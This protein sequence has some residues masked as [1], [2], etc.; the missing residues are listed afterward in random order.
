VDRLTVF[1]QNY[2]EVSILGFDVY[3]APE[4]TVD[5]DFLANRLGYGAFDPVITDSRAI[6]SLPYMAKVLGHL[7]Y[8][9]AV[10]TTPPLPA[11]RP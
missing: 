9:V 4:A 5:L 2:A 6:R 10:F 11:S 8:C 3:P 7:H 1:K